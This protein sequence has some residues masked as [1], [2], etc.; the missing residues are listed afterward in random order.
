MT[1]V[2]DPLESFIVADFKVKRSSG[3]TTG[4]M[5]S[6]LARAVKNLLTPRPVINASLCTKCG[7]CVRVCPS[8]PKAVDFRAAGKT[9]P[10]TYEYGV[11]IRCYCCQELCPESAITVVTPPVGRLIGR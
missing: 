7:T 11:C 8:T 6:Y 4:A 9:A 1:T 10:P 5:N 2:G 3:S